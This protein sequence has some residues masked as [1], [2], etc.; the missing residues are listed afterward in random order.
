MITAA[1]FWTKW[2]NGMNQAGDRIRAGVNAVLTTPGYDAIAQQAK[3]RANWLNA[4][5]GGKWATNLGAMTVEG[6]RAAMIQKGIPRIAD[7]VRGAQARVTNFATALLQFENQLQQQVRAMP[8]ATAGD[9]EARVIAW[10]RG[11]KQ[12]RYDRTAQ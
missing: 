12:F 8:N 6:W 5:D 11:M 9:K 1:Q 7:G 3:M 2:S 4:I 10:M